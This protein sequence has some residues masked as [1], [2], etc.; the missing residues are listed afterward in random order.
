MRLSPPPEEPELFRTSSKRF[1]FR[2]GIRSR[3]QTPAPPA[4]GEVLEKYCV[5]HCKIM[6]LS[7]YACNSVK[8][9]G[10]VA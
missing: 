9:W 10:I 3:S 4:D 2:H 8:G 1:S 5:L 6:L 7:K